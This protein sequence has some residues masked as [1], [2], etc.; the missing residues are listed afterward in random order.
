[1][2]SRYCPGCAKRFQPRPQCPH[3]QY[4][5]KGACQQFRK[6]RW[7]QHKLKT[8]AAYRENQIEARQEKKEGQVYHCTNI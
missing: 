8:D 7:Q 4:C 3:Q 6:K 2:E 5:S 1:M